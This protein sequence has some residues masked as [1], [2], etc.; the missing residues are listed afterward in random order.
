MK[1]L[2]LLFI[3]GL[4]ITISCIDEPCPDVYDPVCTPDRTQYGNDCEAR[5]AGVKE[6]TS[7][8]DECFLE[9]YSPVCGSD[10]ITYPNACYAGREGI[11]EYTEGECTN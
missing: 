4:L 6:Y 10:G 1:Y 7:C 2:K 5:N 11:D 8:F 3:V 9:E